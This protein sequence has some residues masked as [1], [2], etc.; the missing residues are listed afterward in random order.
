MKSI[1]DSCADWEVLTPLTAFLAVFSSKS[2][3][4]A[5]FFAKSLWLMVCSLAA[6]ITTRARCGARGTLQ[7]LAVRLPIMGEEHSLRAMANMY[8]CLRPIPAGENS[9]RCAVRMWQICWVTP[10]E[11]WGRSPFYIGGFDSHCLSIYYRFEPHE[12]ERSK[13]RSHQMHT[14]RVL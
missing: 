6:A 7:L 12:I 2:C 14:T 8:W 9:S 5:S 3:F 11:P 1:H 4:S 10:S 13:V